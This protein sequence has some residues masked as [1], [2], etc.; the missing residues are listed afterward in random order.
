MF[1]CAVLG[2]IGWVSYA[3][4][5]SAQQS[6][7]PEQA[8]ASA[9]PVATVPS[10]AVVPMD[11]RLPGDHWTVEGRDAIAGTVSTTISVVTE[12]TPT[13]ISVRANVVPRRQDQWR[14][15]HHF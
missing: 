14:K 11:E 5:A 2:L 8:P 6:S 4:A 15:L 1:R 10:N 13:D 12:V 3:A 9:S 7:I